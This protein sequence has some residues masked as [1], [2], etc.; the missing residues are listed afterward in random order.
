MFSATR[1]DTIIDSL[2][3]ANAGSGRM[4]RLIVQLGLIAIGSVLLAASAQF[5][6]PVPLSPVP[7]TGQTLVVLMIGMA[8]G[9]RLGAMTICAYILA[10][11]RGL[12]VF[13]GGMAG[14]PVLAGPSGGYLVGFIAAAF[15]IGLLAQRGMDRSI[16]MT[17]LAM[18]VGN[19]VIYLFGYA[20]LASLIGMQK[21]FMF[22]VWSFLWGDAIKLV[23][24]A[25]LMPV[26]WRGVKL[27]GRKPS[28]GQH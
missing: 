12:P 11:L 22:G 7:V 3:P 15:V 27:L 17:A 28:D 1:H 20:W 16:L 23:V 6:V 26:V 19:L 21:A 2:M 4:T 10:G 24:A 8:Y 18:L 14:L 5:K 25:C 13:A 9:P